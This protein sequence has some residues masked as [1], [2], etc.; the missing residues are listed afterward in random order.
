MS[1]S[2][3]VIVAT[4]PVVVSTPIVWIALSLSGTVQFAAREFELS[5]AYCLH[6]HPHVGFEYPLL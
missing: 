1:V 4:V 2:L 5:L 3:M 6:Q